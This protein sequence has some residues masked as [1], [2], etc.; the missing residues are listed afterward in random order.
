MNKPRLEMAWGPGNREPNR[1]K[2][3]GQPRV[4]AAQLATVDHESDSGGG[5]SPRKNTPVRGYLM[6]LI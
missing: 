1:G 3:R 4:V 6:R 5:V 2:R